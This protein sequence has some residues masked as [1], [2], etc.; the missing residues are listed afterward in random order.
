MLTVLF[1]NL[2]SVIH[3][4][5]SFAVAILRKHIITK[6]KASRIVK[7][8]AELI[9]VFVLFLFLVVFVILTK[10][11]LLF[12]HGHRGPILL[13]LVDLAADDRALLQL[14]VRVLLI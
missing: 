14:I 2:A 6:T 1:I 13:V 9:D 11:I 4:L 12:I 5:L 8:A 3:R 7:A 10:V